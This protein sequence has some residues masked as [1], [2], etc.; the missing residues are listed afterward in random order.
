MH[1]ITYPEYLYENGTIWYSNNRTEFNVTAFVLPVANITC[2]LQQQLQE[3]QQQELQQM[4]GQA[5]ELEG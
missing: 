4:I 2:V 5:A 1:N 3:Q